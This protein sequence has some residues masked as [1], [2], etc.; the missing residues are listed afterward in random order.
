MKT[1]FPLS[2]MADAAAKKEELTK[3]LE[4][5]ERKYEQMESIKMSLK[6][7]S[8]SISNYGAYR[9]YRKHLDEMD[10]CETEIYI[11]KEKL[12]RMNKSLGQ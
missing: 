1:F 2:K 3:R 5:L 9:E 6:E 4:K 8:F 12:D 7:H 10:D 11:L